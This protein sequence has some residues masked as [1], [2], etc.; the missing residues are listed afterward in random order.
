M[1]LRPSALLMLALAGAAEAAEPLEDAMYDA[2]RLCGI[3]D[4][5]SVESCGRS[6]GRSPEHS[7]AR[8]AVIR[9][10]AARGEFMRNCEKSESLTDCQYMAEYRMWGGF[11]HALEEEAQA[12]RV[13]TD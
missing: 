2:V 6:I 13:K 1:R 5:V 3:I 10:L 9:M 7:A 4:S 11:N 12:K 8:K